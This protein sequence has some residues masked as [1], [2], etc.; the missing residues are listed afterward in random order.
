MTIFSA[1]PLLLKVPEAARMLNVSRTTLYELMRAGD[2]RTV[3]IGRAVRVPVRE[4][5]RWVAEQQQVGEAA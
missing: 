4:L 3:R 5:E 1:P 2:I